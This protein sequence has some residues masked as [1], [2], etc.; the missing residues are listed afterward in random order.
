MRHFATRIDVGGKLLSNLL[1]ETLSYKEINLKGETAIVN[2]I[3]E[4]CTFVSSRFAQDLE[5]SKSG[6]HAKEFV[7]P[8]YTSIK[9]GYIRD[10]DATSKEQV[11]RLACERFTIPEVLF[12]PSDI[13]INQAGICESII[14]TVDKCPK[15]MQQQLLGNIVLTGGN[16]NIRGFKGRIEQDLE[17]L[18]PWDTQISVTQCEHPE[19]AVWRGLKQ[20]S[21]DLEGHAVTRAEWKENGL[22]AFLPCVL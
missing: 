22:R 1:M 19:Q 17:S 8:D 10:P 4:S 18:K 20:L 11:V 7:L 9:R 15:D 13:G 2:Q 14:Q 6:G 16:C 12:S 21:G 3:K 5:V